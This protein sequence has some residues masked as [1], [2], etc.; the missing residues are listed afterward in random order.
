MKTRALVLAALVWS[1]AACS[2]VDPYRSVR[3]EIPSLTPFNIADYRQILVVPFK[4]EAPPP[5][6][7]P[8]AKEATAYLAEEFGREFKGRVVT[9]EA[10]EAGPPAPTDEAAPGGESLHNRA[11]L[12]DQ[13]HVVAVLLGDRGRRSGQARP[14]VGNHKR[15]F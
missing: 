8:L 11:A 7:F 14:A 10:T 6:G 13:Q 5:A 1:A 2:A 15:D 4:E 3:L 12:R 9:V